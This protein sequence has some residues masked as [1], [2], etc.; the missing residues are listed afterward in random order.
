MVEGE[1]GRIMTEVMIERKSKFSTELKEQFKKMNVV[2]SL[3]PLN[4]DKT[5]KSLNAFYDFVKKQQV[6]WEN[7][8]VGKTNEIRNYFINIISYLDQAE[9]NQQSNL[10]HSIN[11]LQTAI[12]HIKLKRFPCVFSSPE[13][14]FVKEQYEVHHERA[15]AVC[16]YLL[17]AGGNNQINI[18]WNNPKHI[19]GLLNGFFYKHPNLQGKIFRSLDASFDALKTRYIDSLNKVDEEY[20]DKMDAVK[21]SNK[22]YIGETEAWK[23]N[24]TTSSE[25]FVEEKKNELTELIRLYEEKL[26]LEAPARYW[27]ETSKEYYAKGKLW[28]W[29]ASITAIVFI[30]LLSFILF[31]LPN[32]PSM[33]NFASLKMTIVL[34]VIISSGLFLIN[35]FI[36]LAMSAFHLSTDAKERNKLT[37]VYLALLK[38]KSVEESD[39]SI[40]L[41]SLFSRA[42]SGLLKGDSSPT[43]PD[44][45][46]G[47]TIKSLGQ[48]K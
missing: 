35:L 6:Y 34:T 48:Q 24:L 46:I 37:Y 40:V 28:V 22:S 19:E 26:K 13:A 27:E 38:D 39:R 8:T 25:E 17:D 36:R 12:N 31:L 4:E 15:D 14:D 1:G 32:P 30:I 3:Y 43:L 45:L 10:K 42:D 9:V 7:C 44:G 33:L 2:F 5:F 20:F 18:T 23:E 41:Q 11:L 21:Q 16:I 29:V 47:Q